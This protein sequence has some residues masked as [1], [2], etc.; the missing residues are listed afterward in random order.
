VPTR[1]LVRATPN[2]ATPSDITPTVI[3]WPD[4]AFDLSAATQCAVLEGPAVATLLAANQ[5]SWF[6]QNGTTYSLAARP[7]LPGDASC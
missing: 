1:L 7:A 2:P 3:P 5:L 6:T 4:P